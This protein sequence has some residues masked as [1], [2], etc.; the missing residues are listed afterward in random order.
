MNGY[1]RELMP[2][3]SYYDRSGIARH[4]EQ[5]AA[6]G[7]MLD[8]L[9]GWSWRYRRAEPQRLRFSIT[10]FPSA[11]QYDP[12]P[13][14][15]L[16]T[17][18]DYCAQAGW[19][20]AADNAQVQIFY[21]S[22][23]DAVPLETDPAAELANIRAT[24]RK[25]FLP[26]WLALL[27]LAL[28]Q[29]GMLLWQ[30]ILDPIQQLSSPNALTSLVAW[31]PLVVLL[32]VELLRYFLWKRR[33]VRAVDT[34]G[35]LPEL[36]SARLLSGLVLA[37]SLLSLAA[38]FFGAFLFSPRMLLLVLGTLLSILLVILLSRGVTLL[39]RRRGVSARTNRLATLSLI[40]VLAIA[41]PVGMTAVL[42]SSSWSLRG[43]P[44][45][46][47]QVNG[48][49]FQVYHDE[50]PMEMSDLME[51]DYDLWSTTADESAT[52]LLARREY[53]QRPRVD[54]PREVPHLEYSILEIRQPFLYGTCK[55]AMLE[56]YWYN[57][58][59]ELRDQFLPADPSPWGA[60]E[61]YQR[62][63]PPALGGGVRPCYLLCWPERIVEI[64]LDRE[65]S[66]AQMA[67]AGRILRTA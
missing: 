26:S 66:P 13:S 39:L 2:L 16:E 44:A 5:M 33:A 63:T 20:L 7:W 8:R 21:S 67:A 55:Q 56:K 27:L 4:L 41:I 18:R 65:L 25:S 60:E 36:R 49:T 58:P 47:Y 59:P 24:M 40:V 31:I 43:A 46:T 42:L 57:D 17:L 14:E 28:L 19:T 48:S 62:H 3:Y 38:T 6:K 23:P 10:Y 30:L 45:E 35:P 12:R 64:S 37:F 32:T 61:V 53:R 15:G 51:V 52:F 34:G 1:K 11:S 22:D 9:G 50:I 29:E 54:A